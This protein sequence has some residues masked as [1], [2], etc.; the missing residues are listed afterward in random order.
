[1]QSISTPLILFKLHTVTG[2]KKK[3]QFM[4]CQGGRLFAFTV[5]TQMWQTLSAGQL[6][7][8]LL[9]RGLCAITQWFYPMGF[10]MKT[11]VGLSE[12]KKMGLTVCNPP[13][14]GLPL[15]PEQKETEPSAK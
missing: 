7:E 15:L 3:I 11:I 9:C 12:H 10:R 6:S 5:T 1:M 8:V 13:H 14:S 2:L 4:G